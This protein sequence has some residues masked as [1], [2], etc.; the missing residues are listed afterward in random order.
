MRVKTEAPITKEKYVARVFFS[1]PFGGLEEERELLTKQYWPELAHLC[2]KSG[3]EFVPVD[4]RWGITSELSNEA[5]TITICL[6]ELDRSDMIVGFFGQRYG[7]HGAK[8][9]F[10]QKTF[11]HALPLYPWLKSY[12]DRAV[13][14]LEFL[15]G[16]LNDPGQRPACF[17]F[18]DKAYDDTKLAECITSGDER[19]QRKFKATSD[20]PHAAEFL[21]DLKQRV[22]KTEDKCLAI[23]MSYPTPEVGARL[24]FETVHAHLVRLL[25]QTETESSEMEKEHAQ[26]ET[27]LI[28]RRGMGGKLVGGEA[29]LEEIDKHALNG[30]GREDERKSVVLLG[31]AGSGKSCVLAN[32]IERHRERYSDDILA[33]HFVGCTSNST[34]ELELLKH[35][36]YQIEEDLIT[37]R[38]DYDIG[39]EKAKEGSE[40]VR[41]MRKLLQ[42]LVSDASSLNIRV[43]IVIDALNKIDAGGRAMKELYWLPKMISS[44]V[45]LILSTSNS[46]TKNI[47]ELLEE[48]H[49]DSLEVRQLTPD[50]RTKVTKGMLMVRGKEL[51]PKQM[52]KVIGNAETGNPL[53]LFILLQELCSFGSFFELDEFIDTLLTSKS[54]VDLFVKFLERLERDYNPEGKHLVKEVLCCLLLAH[55]GLSENELKSMVK[56]TNKEWSALY[57]AMDDFLLEAEGLYRLGYSELADAVERHFCPTLESQKPYRQLIVNHFMNTFK[58]LDQRF[59]TPVPRRIADE[60]P[61]Q[62]EKSGQLGELVECLSSMNMFCTLSKGQTKYDLM[63]YWT[64]TNLSG[65]AIIER[66]LSA[67]DDQVTLLYLENEKVGRGGDAGKPPA[68]QLIPLLVSLTDFLTDAGYSSSMEPMLL[69]ALNMHKSQYTDADIENSV[70]A[71]NSYCE[72]Q[73]KLAVHYAS[74]EKL[75]QASK[76]HLETL[77][78]REKHVDRVERG[79]SYIAVILNNLGYICLVEHKFKEAEGHFRRA[80]ELH[81]EVHGNNNDLVASAVNNVGMALYRQG[82]FKEA[83][84]FLEESLKIYEE[85][86]LGELPPDVGGTLLNLA[87]CTARQADKGLEDVEPLY[88]RALEIRMNAVGKNHPTV[89][90]TYLSYGSYLMRVDKLERALSMTKDA[91]EISEIASGPEHQDTLMTL[92]N[93]A[94][95]YV[96]LNKP[97]EAHPY[98]KRA[99][100]ALHKQGRMEF[101]HPYL[102]SSMITYYLSSDR[103]G[104]A[105]DALIRVIGTS[106]VSPRDYAALDYLDS[107][108]AEKPSRPYEHSVDCGLEKFPTSTMLLGRKLAQLAPL[109][110]ADEMIAVLEKGSFD[111]GNYNSAYAEFVEKDQR[112]NGLKILERA[113]EK[114]PEDVIIRENLA[115]GYFC[116]KRHGE[117]AEVLGQALRLD[118]ENLDLVLLRVRVLALDNQLLEAQDL[119]QVGLMIAEK[120]GAVEAEAKLEDFLRVL[121]EALTSTAE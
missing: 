49:F 84:Q 22:K 45:L 42:R 50:L 14:E 75:D 78:L 13:T 115:K 121:N 93:I 109:G 41:G 120:K 39:D 103:E 77:A 60:L 40:D 23:D 73:T 58:D 18:R 71:L 43:I 64:T 31:D 17:F 91:L 53:Y 68:Q 16:H 38:P 19:G 63:S 27:F 90:Q 62:L 104:D 83:G 76:I 86:Y 65:D 88:Q 2:Q 12:R 105:H 52:E 96:S 24:M 70:D 119:I 44:K 81:R 47:K 111:V 69:R 10:L 30:L 29:Y 89:A 92:E 100:E 8:D 5:A 94:L 37:L 118:E 79:K 102:N 98:Y 112:E 74:A 26:H 11:D 108:L 9:E 46:D 54:T 87:M 101:S 1:S 33:V 6:R 34:R 28:T 116:Y 7:W 85:V 67:V 107:Q 113:V 59:D 99:G 66:L 32:W 56:P 117:A 72:L 21:D 25:G 57:F 3:Y 110:K 106:F 4:M 82:Q 35:L 20:G 51:S 80:V 61:W 95:A 97:E 48:R 36:C 15:H 114:F 55:R